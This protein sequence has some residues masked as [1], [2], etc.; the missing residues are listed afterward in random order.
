MMDGQA[1]DGVTLDRVIE[2]DRCTD[3]IIQPKSFHAIRLDEGPKTSSRM[4]TF[5]GNCLA[6]PLPRNRSIIYGIVWSG[7]HG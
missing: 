4:I 6:I 2:T 3:D 5:Y 7:S 1:M